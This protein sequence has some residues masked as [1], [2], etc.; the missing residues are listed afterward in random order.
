MLD[1]RCRENGVEHRF[2]KSKHAWANGQVERMD[3][4]IKE[5]AVRRYYYDSREQFRRHLDDLV[6][7]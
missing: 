6:N 2:T 4:T 3:R 7:A 5:A 1:L